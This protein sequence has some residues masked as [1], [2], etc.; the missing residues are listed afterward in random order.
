VTA[1]GQGEQDGEPEDELEDPV[2]R[3]AAATEERDQDDDHQRRDRHHAR[4]EPASHVV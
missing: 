2:A 1:A 4:D 3:R